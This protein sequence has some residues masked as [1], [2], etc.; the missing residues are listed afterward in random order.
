MS[1]GVDVSKVVAYAAT[2]ARTGVTVSKVVAYA[3]LNAGSESGGAV[4]HR[5]YTYGQRLKQ[6]SS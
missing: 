5:S 2:G 1:T 6:E 4:N 3:V